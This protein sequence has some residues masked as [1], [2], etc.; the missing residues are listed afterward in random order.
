MS[1][2]KKSEK[3]NKHPPHIVEG[4]LTVA[5]NGVGYVDTGEE[6][7]EDIQ[8]QP[9]LLNTALNQDEVRVAILPKSEDDTR[10]QGEVI[11]VLKRAK[12]EFIGTIDKKN[13]EKNFAFVVPD[14]PRMQTDIFIPDARSEEIKHNH[15]ALVKITDWG[16]PKKNLSGEIVKV[17]GKKGRHEVEMQAILL[18]SGYPAD[19]SEEATKEAKIIQ[20]EAKPISQKEKDLRTNLTDLTI[21]SIDPEDAKDLDD[22]LSVKKIEDNLFEVGIH[23]ADVTHY[24]KEGTAIDVNA[25]DKGNSV[26]LV[27]RTVHML[28]EELSADVCSLNP[29]EEKLA[30]SAIFKV[31]KQGHIKNRWFG[32]SVINSKA[33][34]SYEEAQKAIDTGKGKYAEELRILNEISKNL[35]KQKEE[36]GALTF[37]QPEIKFEF[38]SKGKPIRVLEKKLLP[39]HKLIEE[40]M[41]MAN[42]EVAKYIYQQA[43]NKRSL[44]LY[45]IH[46][47]PEKKNVIELIGF[48]NALG[49]DFQPP[50]SE[51]ISSKKLN[52]LFKA[53]E[54]K[55][56]EYLVETMAMRDM[57]KAVYSLEA[58]GHYGLALEHYTHF[59]SPIRRYAD[60]MVHR[61]LH[62][63]LEEKP[64]SAKKAKDYKKITENLNRKEANAQEAERDSIKY[65]QVEY[66]LQHKGET[67]KG[68]VAGV[69]KWGIFVQEN[70]TKASGLVKIYDMEDDYYV[71]DKENY[72]LRGTHTNK[73]YTI[74]DEIKIKV[75]GGDTEQK[76]LDYK[77]VS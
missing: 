10:T 17:L 2:Q 53:V 35:Q 55:S 52:E 67:F 32:K 58:K 57:E 54:G 28:P 73:K 6:E 36:R 61:I 1:E 60:M 30:F 14:N 63:Y 56:E 12:D 5:Q 50:K 39:A 71:L 48:L 66:M 26:Y 33:R 62:G 18:G 70:T 27:D 11:K 42:R 49:Y 44:G 51:N 21:F 77:I 24:V 7:K 38:D 43:K 59:T 22:A 75:V 31:D 15:K 69:F 65:K 29:G 76:I 46:E 20:K 16:S 3:S 40:F 23:I 68:V 45:R 72:A 9:H 25:K 47:P 8:I 64:V 37:E 41:V 34:F 13:P 4:I 74:G 19:F